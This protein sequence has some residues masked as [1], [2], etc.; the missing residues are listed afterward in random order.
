MTHDGSLTTATRNAP[1][2]ALEL[3]ACWTDQVTH[4]DLG[5]RPSVV[6]GRTDGCDVVVPDGAVSRAHA[7]LEVGAAGIMLEDLGSANGSRVDGAQITGRVPVGVGSLIEIGI[8]RLLVR[9]RPGGLP[10]PMLELHR[11]VD[12]VAPSSVSL[13]IIGET[14]A[15]KEVLT[16]AIHRRSGRSGP[17][18]RINCA[19]LAATL[20][21]SELFGYEKGAFTGAS[22]AKL[23]LIESADGGTLFLD[24]V[25]EMPAATQQKL[26]RVLEEHEVRRVGGVE[27]RPIDVRFVAATHRDLRTLA[28]MGQFREDLLFRLNGLTLR[29][30][31]LRERRDEI[32]AL[33]TE[34]LRAACESAGRPVPVL[35]PG[36]RAVLESYRWPGNIRELKNVIGRVALL[37][38]EPH[39]QVSHLIFDPAL[40]DAPAPAAQPSTEPAAAGPEDE[41]QRILR[42]LARVGGNQAAAAKALGMSARQLAY[43]MDK[44]GIPR[45]RR[46]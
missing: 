42:E 29:V 19:G 18:V 26:L 8:A 20:L 14:G 1:P 23:G 36:V 38:D 16:E 4:V 11:T 9:A 24:E 31:A 27:G 22:Q 12:R 43:R 37:C 17:L 15:G 32:A 21:D 6:I 44:V 25:G 30:P 39:V 40:S 7:R 13:V 45:P 34:F 10:S 3:V 35:S 2:G 41:R 28:I 5:A 46:K 33:S